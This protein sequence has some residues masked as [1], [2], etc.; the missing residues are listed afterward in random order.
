MAVPHIARGLFRT[1]GHRTLVPGAALVGAVVA[2]AA[3]LVTHG[4]AS[5]RQILH[6]NTVNALVGA[7]V[8]LWIVLRGARRSTDG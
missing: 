2:L 3:D 1:S 7:P 5:S 6:L 8:V 4:S